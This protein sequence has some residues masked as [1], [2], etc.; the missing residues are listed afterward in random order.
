MRELFW[1]DIADARP[2]HVYRGV[3]LLFCASLMRV[4]DGSA[5]AAGRVKMGFLNA[6]RT[7]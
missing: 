4:E 7:T 1:K 6:T 5:A 3:A 2:V